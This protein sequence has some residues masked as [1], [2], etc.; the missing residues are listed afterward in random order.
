[1]R[2]TRQ[3]L[4]GGFMSTRR[5]LLAGFGVAAG[6]VSLRLATEIYHAL[7]DPKV[8]FGFGS[9]GPDI[10]RE[11]PLVS[12]NESL[13]STLGQTQGPFYAWRSPRR[14]DIRDAYPGDST[15]VL[16]GYVLD[17]R[18]RRL[19]GYV[20]DFWQTDETARYDAA[21]YRYRGHQFT[22]RQGRFQAG[23]HRFRP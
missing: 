2:S 13:S 23:A 8:E 7:T 17:T 10:E 15:L 4:R 6:A 1:V 9:V 19:P 22:D 21:G 20:L 5:D 12:A 3:Q 18:G 16:E 11:L 14:R